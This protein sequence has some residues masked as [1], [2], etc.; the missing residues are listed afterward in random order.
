MGDTRTG[1]SDTLTSKAI[2]ICMWQQ[3][4]GA[5]WKEEEHFEDVM[6]TRACLDSVNRCAFFCILLICRLGCMKRRKNEMLF[7][8][9]GRRLINGKIITK[10]TKNKNKKNSGR[11]YCFFFFFFPP[12]VPGLTHNPHHEDAA[13]IYVHMYTALHP[14]ILSVKLFVNTP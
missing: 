1:N 6:I 4:W 5:E 3:G 9:K 13:S 11:N 8:V 10:K 12:K 14:Y 7:P 2:V